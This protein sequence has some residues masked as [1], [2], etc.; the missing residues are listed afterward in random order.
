[1]TQRL[2]VRYAFNCK[3]PSE[4]GKRKGLGRVCEPLLGSKA[5]LSLQKQSGEFKCKT[6]AEMTKKPAKKC[7]DAS[8]H[9]YITDGS[10]IFSM[11]N[12]IKMLLELRF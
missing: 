8:S 2:Q 7:L 10:C 3:V 1:M 11:Y 5:K 9:R 12:V 6:W 4:R